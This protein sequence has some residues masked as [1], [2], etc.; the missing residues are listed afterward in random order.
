MLPLCGG[1]MGNFLQCFKH[2]L[3]SLG[4]GFPLP[5]FWSPIMCNFYEFCWFYHFFLFFFCLFLFLQWTS[6]NGTRQERSKEQN[7][8]LKSLLSRNAKA[9]PKGFLSSSLQPH[10]HWIDCV[11]WTTQP[12]G[13]MEKR[14][15]SVQ[16]LQS[17]ER[18]VTT[19]KGLGYGDGS[20]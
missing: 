6:E 10:P 2:L 18:N 14:G 11:T 1:I 5:N 9:F 12:Q 4:R 7:L 17:H 15:F 8:L 3:I 19:E 20:S 13:T 16:P